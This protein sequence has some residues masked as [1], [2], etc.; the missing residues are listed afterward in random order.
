MEEN[1]EVEAADH[2]WKC[3]KIVSSVKGDFNIGE[4]VGSYIFRGDKDRRGY[5]SVAL[6]DTKFFHSTCYEHCTSLMRY[7]FSAIRWDF[8]AMVYEEDME[9]LLLYIPYEMLIE[10]GGG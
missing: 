7:L 5:N 4:N 8:F 1:T 10:T 6:H 2:D 3:E 9:K